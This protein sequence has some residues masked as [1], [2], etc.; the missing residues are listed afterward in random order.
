MKAA[1]SLHWELEMEPG[2]G[3]DFEPSL[4][5]LLELIDLKGSVKQAAIRIDV[6][7]RYAW[8]LF[9]KWEKILGQPLILMQRGRG[10]T[11]TPA[12]TQ[13]LR[14]WQQ[15]QRE[16]APELDTI[17]AR[18]ID[19]FVPLIA[20]ESQ[21][22][23]N[24]FASHDL[25]VTQ[26]RDLV[27]LQ[28]T[29]AYNFEIDLHF[30]A[31]LEALEQ[32]N[33]KHCDLAGFHIPRSH[34][35]KELTPNFL[36]LLDDTKLR[37]FELVS[38]HQGLIVAPGNPKEINSLHDLSRKDIVFINRQ[39]DSGTRLLFDQLLKGEAIN[40]DQI[41]GYNN[42]EFTHTA[43]AALVASGSV[44]VGFGIAPCADAL[45]LTF[46]PIVWEDYYLAM[47][48]QVS[49]SATADLL[50]KKLQS[51]EFKNSLSNYSGYKA[52]HAGNEIT[53]KSIFG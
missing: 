33:A 44:D 49:Q 7:Y 32:L 4:F 3:H 34:F 17:A 12:G 10:A 53:L 21:E 16:L 28:S 14:S 29:P 6:S 24:L 42:E 19:E 40:P 45:G 18:F 22:K 31:S 30:H 38:R 20:S 23:L 27:N 46:I 36:P 13:L 51:S 1:L 35:R 47:S 26:L 5:E 50:V 9:Q 43:V 2:N 15:A 48:E 39:A 52:D 11:L 25:A 41:N 37:I 8:G